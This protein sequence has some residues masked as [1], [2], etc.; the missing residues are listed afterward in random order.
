MARRKKGDTATADVPKSEERDHDP[1]GHYDFCIQVISP[2]G[3]KPLAQCHMKVWWHSRRPLAWK[4]KKGDGTDH[5][6]EHV[7]REWTPEED[8]RQRA[9]LEE[10]ASQR[11]TIKGETAVVLSRMARNK[12]ILDEALAKSPGG[13]FISADLPS[14]EDEG[15]APLI[16]ARPKRKLAEKAASNITLRGEKADANVRTARKVHSCSSCDCTIGHGM[17]YLES[18]VGAKSAFE[19]FRYCAKCWPAEGY[20]VQE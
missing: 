3:H 1:N 9:L 18:R 8:G 16:P 10:I 19:P 7:C 6:V 20:E 13:I 12:K 15:F 17:K 14:E 4:T 5:E 11:Y 2:P